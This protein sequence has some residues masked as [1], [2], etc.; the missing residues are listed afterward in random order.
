MT[1]TPEPKDQDQ[2]QPEAPAGP[3]PGNSP[4]AQAPKTEANQPFAQPQ[5]KAPASEQEPDPLSQPIDEQEG[6]KRRRP[7]QTEP[8]QEEAARQKERLE[9]QAKLQEDQQK[10]IQQREKERYIEFGKRNVTLQRLETESPYLREVNNLFVEPEG[11]QQFEQQVRES[12]ENH[13]LIVAGQERSGKRM[14]AFYLAQHLWSKK[15]LELYRFVDRSKKT[16]LEI[17]SDEKLPSNAVILLEEVINKDQISPEDL[18][19]P[20]VHQDLANLTN[21]WFIF[22]VPNGPILEGIQARK[23]PILF[24]KGVNCQQVLEKLIDVFFPEEF[25][26]GNDRAE[27]LATREVLNPQLTPSD[28]RQLFDTR[29]NDPKALFNAL[30]KK[31][32][33]EQEAPHIWF[34]ELKPMNYQLYALLV[35]LFDK[36]DMPTLEEIYTDAVNA[37][38]RQGMDGPDEFID[39]RRIGTNLMHTELGIQV[40][41]NVLEF[42][43]RV[44]RQ[45]VEAQVENFQ[46]LL[47]SLIDPDDPSTFTGLVGAIRR[48]SA[49][50]LQLAS[51]MERDE[52]YIASSDQIRQLRYAIA[53]MIAQVGV[54]H[55]PKLDLLLGKLVHDESALVALTAAFVLAEIARRGEHFDFIEKLLM[56][57]CQS[58]R[59]YQMWAAAASIAHIYEAIARTLE[60]EPTPP[61][62][63]DE[64][65][66]ERDE[67]RKATTTQ[68]QKQR[69][70][71]YLAKLRDILTELVERHDSFSKQ[72]IDEERR[73]RHDSHI[74]H[75]AQEL[76]NDPEPMPDDGRL[77]RDLSELEQGL[78]LKAVYTQSKKTIDEA[79]ER[80]I[81]VLTTSWQNQMRMVLMQTLE[82]I[83]QMWPRD[84]TRLVRVWFDRKDT[85][86]RLYQIGHMALNYLFRESATIKDA[87]LLER[88]AY[89]LLE[90]I[91]MA[92]RTHTLTVGVLLHD[93][94]L[95]LQIEALENSGTL[96]QHLEVGKLLG[97]D[98]WSMRSMPFSAGM[99]TCLFC[100]RDRRTKQMADSLRRMRRMKHRVALWRTVCKPAGSGV[101]IQPCRML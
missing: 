24:T 58:G 87:S 32:D 85:H 98:P 96:G 27:L 12:P 79:V 94:S 40:H 86:S 76:K 54:H 65:A 66:E 2:R 78:Y 99:K 89:P 63:E 51:Q 42:R 75:L 50:D 23:F 53:V 26:F 81:N 95:F 72:A 16:L 34:N 83:A 15:E 93:L 25:S 67:E 38:R 20:F 1:E 77:F 44:Y 97:D 91:P 92:M 21:V 5:E 71:R 56:T 4:D 14:T 60:D 35:V 22:T 47:W 41:F 28:L 62:D 84:I 48:L 11:Y 30:K 57:W 64:L 69:G 73:N 49:Y 36:L 55:L 6:A 3:N 46:R 61:N 59:F 45:Y 19:S 7:A 29:R 31:A 90:L 13:I 52:S 10:R 18:T 37:L 88:S 68:D 33:L 43:S 80:E 70:K 74:E 17:V 100:Q 8:E 82:H 39:P 101:S 9:E